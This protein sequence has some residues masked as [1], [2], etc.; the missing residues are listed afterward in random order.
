MTDKQPTLG[1]WSSD[2]IDDN[3]EAAHTSLAT[4]ELPYDYATDVHTISSTSVDLDS[5]SETTQ[6]LN[7][8]NSIALDNN[9]ID[10]SVQALAGEVPGLII[11]DSSHSTP[12]DSQLILNG[13]K[14]EN[15]YYDSINNDQIDLKPL[16][17][18]SFD[19]TLHELK[20][21]TNGSQAATPSDG[22]S[23]LFISNEPQ[24]L[25]IISNNL[26]PLLGDDFANDPLLVYKNLDIQSSESEDIDIKVNGE[27]DSTSEI[28]KKAYSQQSPIIDGSGFINN[29][30]LT[31]KE[32]GVVDNESGQS[33]LREDVEIIEPSSVNDIISL[34]EPDPQKIVDF[35]DGRDQAIVSSKGLTPDVEPYLNLESL[36]WNPLTEEG[37]SRL[38]ED[39]SPLSIP[40]TVKEW[41]EDRTTL[42][43]LGNYPPPVDEDAGLDWHLASFTLPGETA[44]PLPDWLQLVSLE[45]TPE[46]V[47]QGRVVI[48]Q[49]FAADASDPQ[50]QW[51][52]IHVHDGR[53]DGKGLV[54]LE[55]NLDWKASALELIPEELNVDKVF[56]RD[57]LP[58]FQNTGKTSTLE[59]ESTTQ[60][61]RESLIGLGAAALPNGGQGKPLGYLK[62]EAPQT[63][64]ARL[65]FRTEDPSQ[66]P[67]VQLEATLIPAAAG[68]AIEAGDLLILDERSPKVW[69]VQAKPDQEQVGSHAFTLRRGEGDSAKVGHLAVAV[70][71]V[72]DPPE[73]IAASE[74]Q[75]DSLHQELLQDQQL[76][77]DLRHLF[78]DQ[79]DADLEYSLVDGPEWLQVDPQTGELSGIPANADVGGFNITVMADDG[80]GGS[81]QQKLI[82]DVENVNDAPQVG[83][84]IALPNLIQGQSFTYR[85]PE[86]TFNDPDLTI[87]PGERL[88]Y[89]L[90]AAEGQEEVPSWIQI[91]GDNGTLTGTAGPN[92]V[93]A[94][95]MVVRAID[96][97]GLYADQAVQLMVENVNDAP[98]RTSALNNFLKLQQPTAQGET[99]PSEN[100]PNALFTGIERTIELKPWFSDPDM[101][102]VDEERLNLRVELDTGTG[103]V[104]DLA[105]ADE[106]LNQDYDLKWLDWDP[107]EGLLT[108]KPGLNDIGQHILRVRASDIEG[109]EASAIVPLL[110]RHRNSA[111]ILQITNPDELIDNLRGDGFEEAIA[112]SSSQNEE[113]EEQL[114]GLKINLDDESKVNIEL[115]IG[116]FSD[117]DLSIDPAELLKLELHGANEL[118]EPTGSNSKAAFEFD[119]TNLSIKGNTHGLGL[120]R[121]G[122]HCQWEATLTA[123][124]T[125]GETTSFDLIF[126]LQREASTP[127][128][129]KEN[130]SISA[131]EGSTIQL[132]SLIQLSV[133]GQEGEL[134]H[135]TIDRKDS[136]PQSLVLIDSKGTIDTTEANSGIKQRW[137]ISGNAEEIKARVDELQ[138]R[139]PNNS[140]AIGDFTIEI[141]VQTELGETGLRSDP[142]HEILD[143]NLEPEA[144]IPL[145]EQEVSA[146][147]PTDRFSFK[148]IGDYI[149]ARSPDPREVLSYQIKLPE[150]RPDLLI[151]DANG[152]E[153]GERDDN[154]LFLSHADWSKALLRSET[155]SD[156]NAELI[157]QAISIEPNNWIQALSEQK[158]LSWL[159]S[160]LLQEDPEVIIQPPA[161]IQRSGE[162]STVYV[163]LA[164]PEGTRNLQLSISL[165]QGSLINIENVKSAIITPETTS[166]SKQEK[167]Y[168]IT[169]NNTDEPIPSD[170]E[171]QIRSA[172]SF[173]GSFTGKLTAIASTRAEVDTSA[174]MEDW[175]EEINKGFASCIE[176]IEFSWDVAQVARSPEFS[177]DS[178][179]DQPV[180]NFNPNVGALEIPIRRG[181]SSSGMRNA[182]ETLTLAVRNIPTGYALAEKSGDSYKAV[183][184]TD[185]FGTMTLFTIP[186]VSEK[187]Q[188]SNLSQFELLNNG[189]LF[190]VA[191]DSNPS[192]L[193]SAELSLTLTARISDQPGGDSRSIPIL[194]SLQL[195]NFNREIPNLNANKELIDPIIID[196]TRK[197]LPLTSLQKTGDGVKFSMLPEASAVPTAWLASNA[198]TNED[199]NAAFVVLNDTSNDSPDGNVTISS[200]KELLS[201]YFQSNSRERSF[202]SGSSALTSLNSN[203]DKLLDEQDSAW[204]QLQLW[205]DDGDAISQANELKNIGDFLSSIDLGSLETLAVQPE[206]SAGNAVLR[207][208]SGSSINDSEP[209]Y[210]LYDVG[211]RIAPSGKA[212]LDL[213]LEGEES[214]DGEKTKV[215]RLRMSENGAPASLLLL[216]ENSNNWVE[217]GLDTLTLVR[218]AGL[219]NNI[220]PS[221]GVRDSRG[222]W[223]FTWSDLTA[224]GGKLE[225][226]PDPNWSGN[227]NLQVLMS[228]LQADGSLQSS[229]LTSLAL[230]VTSEA[231]KPLL[232]LSNVIINE[233]QSLALNKLLQK[234]ELLD[235]DGSEV[236]HFELSELPAGIKIQSSNDGVTSKVIQPEA[237]VYRFSTAEMKNLTLVPPKDFSGSLQFQW[238]AVATESSNNDKAANSQ[239]ALITI[240][241]VS[242]SPDQIIGKASSLPLQEGGSLA[243]RNLIN[244][245]DATK[246]LTDSDG[247]EQLRLEFVVPSGLTIEQPNNKSWLP[248]SSSTSGG[249][250]IIVIKAKDLQTLNLV[251]KGLGEIEEMKF[252]V[253]RI[254]REISNGNLSRSETTELSLPFARN[255]RKASVTLL[256]QPKSLEDSDGVKLL[257]L[258]KA[259]AANSKDSLSYKISNLSKGL[260]LIN[261][262][263]ETQIFDEQNKELTITSADG[264]LLKTEAN[265]AGNFGFD[266]K[267]VSHPPGA[268]NTATT[269]TIRRSIKVTP[270]AE[271]PVLDIS[272]SSDSSLSIEA[273]G[274][275]KIDKLL[276]PKLTSSDK[277]GS[278]Q[279]SLIIGSVNTN[280]E[281]VNL[282]SQAQLNTSARQLEDGR[283]EVQAIDIDGLSLYLGEIDEEMSISIAARSTDGD[284]I[285]MSE[286]SVVKVA[287]NAKVRVPLLEIRGVMEGL[288]DVPIPLLSKLEG[289]I[290]AKLRGSGAGQTLELGITSLPKD[291]KLVSLK[292]NDA[293]GVALFSAPLNLDEEGNLTSSLKLPYVQW[294]QV[295]WQGPADKSGTFT[296]KVQASSIG[297]DGKTMKSE[298]VDAK[299]ILTPVNDKPRIT[300]SSDLNGVKEGD[301]GEWNLRSR[302]VDTDNKTS[303]LKIDAR[304]INESG[305]KVSLPTW[306]SLSTNGVLSGK[307]TNSDVGMLKIE[308]TA[309]DPLGQAESQQV[310][311]EVGD[312]NAEPVFNPIAFTGWEAKTENQ[313]TT[314]SRK[315]DLREKSSIKLTEAFTDEDIING[316]KLKH[317][318]ST[319]GL[320]WSESIKDL[321]QIKNDELI[322]EATSKDRLGKQQ[323]QLRTS[324]QMGATLTKKMEVTIRNINDAP[325]VNRETSTMLRTGLWQESI[326]LDQGQK[327]W[328]V[329]LEGLFSDADVGDRIDQIAPTDLPAWLTYKSSSTGTGGILSGTPGN[330][331]VGL[332]AM[333][334]QA[335]DNRGDTATYKIK[336]EVNNVNDTPI[337]ISNPDLSG[338]GAVESGV[339]S[340]NEDGYARL[341]LNKLFLDPDSKYGDALSYEITKVVNKVKDEEVDVDWLGLA[342][343]SSVAPDSSNKLLI[344]PKFYAI[345]QNGSQGK[346][347]EADKLGE[348]PSG[349]KLK[350]VVEATD[351]RPSQ[352]DLFPGLIVADMDIT[353]NS[354]LKL[355]EGSASIT[356]KLT[357][358]PSIV[359]GKGGLRFQAGSTAGYGGVR[360]GVTKSENGEAWLPATD[361][362]VSFEAIL[363]DPSKNIL[364]GV[365][366]GEGPNREGLW[367]LNRE[368]F[369]NKNSVIHS[370]ASKSG[371][372]V[373]I[374]APK[375]AEVGNFVIT[376]TSTDLAG[377]KTSADIPLTIL[378][379]N[380]SPVIVGHDNLSTWLA[381]KEKAKI[382]EGKKIDSPLI[383]LFN[384]PDLAH[385]DKLNIRLVPGEN[386]A[387]VKDFKLP[388]SIVVSAKNNGEINLELT[389]PPGLTSEVIQQFRLEV[390][391]QEGVSKDTEWLS[392]LFTPASEPT[393]LSRGEQ[394]QE[395]K[396]FE[397]GNNAK[398]NLSLDLGAALAIN[399][400]ELNDQQGDEALLYLQM[401]SSSVEINLE[402][403]EKQDFFVM[404]KGTN[405]STATI[406]LGRLQEL[407]GQGYGSLDRVKLSIAPNELGLIPRELSPKLIAGL[408]IKIWTETQVK[409]DDA[410]ALFGSKS[411]DQSTIWIPIDNSA[412][413]FKSASTTMINE[414]L[415]SEDM[416]TK[417]RTLFSLSEQFIDTDKEDKASW[418]MKVPRSLRG[419]IE[420]DKETGEVLLAEEVKQLKDLPS[421]N[422]RI[423]VRQ[424][425][426][427]GEIGDASGIGSGV[428]RINVSS[429]NSSEQTIE[430]L[431]LIARGSSSEIK[432]IFNKQVE[433]LKDSEKQVVQIFERLN[434]SESTRDKFIEE[435]EEGSLAILGEPIDG[436]PLV[437][438]DASQSQG[439]LLIKAEKEEASSELLAESEQLLTQQ[440]ISETPIGKLDFSLDTQGQSTS[441]VQMKLENGGA[442]LDALLKTTADGTPYIFE[443][444]KKSY[445]ETRDGD[446][447]NWLSNLQYGLHYYGS[448]TSSDE[449]KLKDVKLRSSDS[450]EN[451]L[452][453]AKFNFNQLGQIDG[454]GFLIDLDADGMTDLISMLLVDEGFFDTIKDDPSTLVNEGIG[455]IG[456]PLIPISTRKAVA[457][458]VSGS[459]APSFSSGSSSSATNEP[460]NTS[461]TGEDESG[462]DNVDEVD[463]VGEVDNV[464]S[465]SAE[466]D[467]QQDAPTN[468][469]QDNGLS[470]SKS[471]VNKNSL[472]AGIGSN[473]ADIDTGERVQTANQIEGNQSVQT[474]PNMANNSSNVQQA[475]AGNKESIPSSTA[476]A[477]GSNQNFMSSLQD[478]MQA[479]KNDAQE[480]LSSLIEPLNNK[481][482][483]SIAAI[484]G[485]IVM[486]ITGERIATNTAKAMNRD[487]RLKLR[488]RE[489]YF[490]GRWLMP[491]RDGR[492]VVIRS[493]S[494]SLTFDDSKN[495]EQGLQD[496]TLL[497]GFD[498]NGS[499]LLSHAIPIC[500]NPGKFVR[501]LISLQ[502]ELTNGK[503]ID[504]NWDNWIQENFL[505]ATN[506]SNKKIVAAQKAIKELILIVQHALEEEPVLADVLML[507]QLKDCSD[508]LGLNVQSNDNGSIDFG[509]DRAKAGLTEKNIIE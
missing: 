27:N 180:L 261:P 103:E 305:N 345:N 176:N 209:N 262:N 496:L 237:G 335:V 269:S 295:H 170:L 282:P 145:W 223:L 52:E 62:G 499:S 60:S 16:E 105:N 392:V 42:L 84:S 490:N 393:I 503:A 175:S 104:I 73:P 426:S 489:P 196:L 310:S 502:K 429:G 427:S 11:D 253:T 19:D 217:S 272:K 456:D 210:S 76:S 405:H 484:L 61:Q 361:Q 339:P 416:T 213:Q 21:N 67:E 352:A 308:I 25:P 195:S 270:V 194:E 116:L 313:L 202:L 422:H 452:A 49:K 205:F 371:A 15:S 268:G 350:V 470:E 479:R 475:D 24:A 320:N 165:P 498:G 448:V 266:L 241:A 353:W 179:N 215:T 34:I 136:D 478:W 119:P 33:S 432:G 153:L 290:D 492:L 341:D 234:A 285:A 338:L 314:Y 154:Y 480:I 465:E 45:P 298:I 198:N 267:I 491:T 302:F 200:I 212:P 75:Q 317:V 325:I 192:D 31:Y 83:V 20:N 114:T 487:L 2:P 97:A 274:W 256:D 464:D 450:I 417:D 140:H 222:D 459:G 228:Q 43:P 337:T 139:V 323:I 32:I 444:T 359:E 336:L 236:L 88:H 230:D 473:N 166:G 4:P 137:E 159:P 131:S 375:N 395:L 169:I 331:D 7:A 372:D 89:E 107:D 360:V 227:A 181:P 254:S 404:K 357:F 177:I 74:L 476:N 265:L 373:E 402:G 425:D 64:F 172:E 183:G 174:E 81:A 39:G 51:L 451:I 293:K 457:S 151:T 316:D 100:D 406:D 163:D 235:K 346:I 387:E 58:L 193:S 390:K 309:T 436:E 79:D 243:L 488:R 182:A 271:K 410:G 482:G 59:S 191:L 342:Y 497:P 318:I 412:P 158:V 250:K 284:D 397:L 94:S 394:Q 96:V 438:L 124:D 155:G 168:L 28:L 348:L 92:D 411:S 126:N 90:I 460:G 447:D 486:P 109:L 66:D 277:D 260:T 184:A 29:S 3:I 276:K 167:T 334:W 14:D 148:A 160:P 246:G 430:G 102:I 494:S 50:K 485:I 333:Q 95:K 297:N 224:N 10:I 219:P 185:A 106:N 495:A 304:L 431:D 248:I 221:L 434:V 38:Q 374:L 483:M 329:N 152:T 344:E 385:G 303:E 113:G 149:T 35:G 458:S 275:L 391:D 218:L 233:D 291:S 264:W 238:Q 251:D 367:G 326:D 164:L 463:N 327:E 388:N 156:L 85:L 389:P 399:A 358:Q 442:D 157:I 409:N 99:P 129:I 408:P 211:L 467:S 22:V 300:I 435:L 477:L 117:P 257:D 86:G 507:S 368:Q 428:L 441:V 370:F 77:H 278:E 504:I 433:D 161:G 220:V 56:E 110:V 471:T 82:I 289:V 18:V 328:K 369:N 112:L 453:I 122:G 340:V 141:N 321:A 319:D 454:S 68:I 311:L 54:G 396:K 9:N 190:L 147:V 446:L 403:S 286:V 201:E 120:G 378:N 162:D 135:L 101:G 307:P 294:G 146:E 280:N 296:F 6:D 414:S 57:H 225:L 401:F 55:L 423:V 439:A 252:S 134:V 70:R 347:I 203:S 324:D 505:P 17:K 98:Y 118:F 379:T 189:N 128:I 142:A 46:L 186:S 255:A 26:P 36:V 424:T 240:R 419:L 231:D 400:L 41:L 288:E 47:G 87:D 420:L 229:A 322:I 440:V 23:G 349:T 130:D 468:D 206:W 421:G 127:E 330:D 72:N 445:N 376:I 53:S 258:I 207:S 244:Q 398:K 509:E 407:T 40:F 143:F 418:S 382:L 115:P 263:K 259:E 362:L 30:L 355:I 356:D 377:E 363:D 125:A 366:V 226:I 354:A 508:Q 144:N 63:L 365:N 281:I 214:K 472:Q 188:E 469:Y 380:D 123:T 283:W 80:R 343:R 108:I 199:Q 111:P 187:N 65:A 306:M 44:A 506:E 93:G 232:Q 299:I 13:E 37:A 1:F 287:A 91:N 474:T 273:N 383:K 351:K 312:L 208:L 173:R 48:S 178:S 245:P 292:G 242:D 466:E 493:E 386:N 78:R 247:S 413:V 301:Q 461:P 69:A 197:G 279:L 501:S 449:D 381:T 437:L 121:D 150:N 415:F 384:D 500:K 332:I 71:E 239:K 12:W 204:S 133:D 462:E 8:N 443:S 364:V 5:N 132:K 216:S 315:L 481:D 138:F 249:Q 455:I 171:L